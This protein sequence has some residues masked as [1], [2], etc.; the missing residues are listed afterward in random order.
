MPLQTLPVLSLASDPATLSRDLGDSFRTF[1]FAMVKDHGLDAA[2]IAR[3]WAL[4]EAFFA[5][6]EAEKRGY[7]VEGQGGARGYTPFG[8]EIAKGAKRHDLKEFWHVGR[9]LPEDHPLA[10]P[11]MPANVW[12]SR[13]EGFRAVFEQLFAEFDRV[14]AAILSHIAVWLGL[15]AHW[16]DPA[17]ADGNSVLRLLHYP[18]VPDAEGGAI[19]AGA[20]EDINLITLLLGAEEAGLELLAK[21]GTWIGVSPPEGALVVNI[22]D[23]LQRLTNHVL[24][25]TTHRVRNPEGPRAGFSRYSMPFFLHLR[26]DFRFETLPSCITPDNPDRYPVS[27][28]ADDY[29]Q[30]RLREIGLKK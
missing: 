12:P 11:S 14:G 5:L 27:I 19:R 29:L 7:F 18:P 8:T 13:P 21:D 4:T 25:S 10:G 22:G 26:S 23:M 2:L 15:D 24:P 1:G 6:P 30:E 16:F 9:T 20:H 3:A 28:T 17:I